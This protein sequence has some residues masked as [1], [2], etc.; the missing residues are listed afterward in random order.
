MTALFAS[1]LGPLKWLLGGAVAIIG[2]WLLG[3]RR[4]AVAARQKAKT[5]DAT[6]A[7]DIRRRVDV[8]KEKHRETVDDLSDTGLNQQLRELRDNAD[9]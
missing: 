9:K 3:N 2:A 4:G 7:N 6:Q 1:L 5:A 8:A